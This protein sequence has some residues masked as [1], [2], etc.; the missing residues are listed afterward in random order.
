MPQGWIP[1]A[2]PKG[3]TPVAEAKPKSE[4]GWTLVSEKKSVNGWTP[5]SHETGITRMA[6]AFAPLAPPVAP[7][8][9]TPSISQSAREVL[10]VLSSLIQKKIAEPLEARKEP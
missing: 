9:E 7:G 5:V 2:K 3:W 4:N 6:K 10:G 8:P 1:V